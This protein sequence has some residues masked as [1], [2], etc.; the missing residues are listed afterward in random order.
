MPTENAANTLSTLISSVRSYAAQDASPSPLNS[1]QGLTDV[2]DGAV[3]VGETS[4]EATA[5]AGEPE[6]PPLQQPKIEGEK[7]AFTDEPHG[8]TPSFHAG[9]QTTTE[10]RQPSPSALQLQYQEEAALQVQL[11]KEITAQDAELLCVPTGAVLQPAATGHDQMGQTVPVPV[12]VL[13]QPAY[14]QPTAVAEPESTPEESELEF[15]PVIQL[16]TPQTPN[17]QTTPKARNA[18]PL[19]AT[20]PTTLPAAYNPGRGRSPQRPPPPPPTAYEYDFYGRRSRVPTPPAQRDRDDRDSSAFMGFESD[21]GG[22]GDDELDGQ[23][24][25]GGGSLRERGRSRGACFKRTMMGESGEDVGERVAE[26]M[27]RMVESMGRMAERVERMGPFDPSQGC[28]PII[29][30]ISSSSSSSSSSSPTP[31]PPPPRNPR[32][33]PPPSPSSTPTH[34]QSSTPSSSST[35]STSSEASTSSLKITHAHK[36]RCPPEVL[37]TGPWNSTERML[38]VESMQGGVD[39]ERL[40]DMMGRDPGDVFERFSDVVAAGLYMG[41]EGVGVGV[42]VGRRDWGVQTEGEGAGI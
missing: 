30:L 11:Q 39:F 15:V 21:G 14:Q 28:V 38:L 31:T 18:R 16:A 9:E 32:K 4:F 36:R 10:Q 33:R 24:S 3:D 7:Q 19:S 13:A 34:S 42:G 2:S 17:V 1:P 27:G 35:T 23:C 29:S 5:V 26:S 6:A 22:D 41:V 25:W 8:Q 12:P 40:G 20:R 37:R